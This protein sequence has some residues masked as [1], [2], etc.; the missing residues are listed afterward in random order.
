MEVEFAVLG[1]IHAFRDGQHGAIDTPNKNSKERTT[2]MKK[3]DRE[4]VKKAQ[5]AQKLGETTTDNTGHDDTDQSQTEELRAYAPASAAMALEVDDDYFDDGDWDDMDDDDESGVGLVTQ[6]MKLESKVKMLGKAEE[7]ERKLF[8]A[9]A[10]DTE[11]AG[12]TELVAETDPQPNTTEPRNVSDEGNDD[13]GE[14]M[15]K[16]VVR[17][18]NRIALE[19]V[20]RGKLAIGEYVFQAIFEGDI[21]E[22]LSKNP[23]KSKS[24][25]RICDDPELLVDRRMLGTWVRAAAFKADLESNLVECSKLTVSQLLAIMKLSGDKN[26]ENRKAL[27]ENANQEGLS[28]R[29]IQAEV[30]KFKKNGKS[31]PAKVLLRKIQDPLNLLED[32]EITALFGDEERLQTELE[33]DTRNDLI[34]AIG[35]MAKKLNAS[36]SFLNST[37]VKLMRIEWAEAVESPQP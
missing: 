1:T 19:T 16:T 2:K 9:D 25:K 5:A 31:D 6:D 37:K 30:S 28:V 36:Q 32:K 29:D 7:E 4:E 23:Y 34:K 18:I 22:A 33:P 12:S 10:E 11:V 35:V 15:A 26:K 21:A 24:L 17:E 13:I 8:S 27:A 3:M 14:A 20:E